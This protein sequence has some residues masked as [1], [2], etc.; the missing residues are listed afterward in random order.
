M[1]GKVWQ[2]TVPTEQVTEVQRQFRVTNIASSEDGADR[3]VLRVL[4]DNQPMPGASVVSSNLE[5]A[6]LYVF[7]E[8]MQS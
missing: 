3:A 4:A 6:Y 1:D 2:V 5:D 7:G 8:A